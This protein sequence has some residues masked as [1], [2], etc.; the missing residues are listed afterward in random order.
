MADHTP[1]TKSSTKLYIE[2]LVESFNS[3]ECDVPEEVRRGYKI[4]L[5]ACHNAVN[6]GCGNPDSMSVALGAIVCAIAADRLNQKKQTVLLTKEVS[7]EVNDRIHKTQ[8]PVRDMPKDAQGRVVVASEN[9]TGLTFQSKLFSLSSKGAAGAIAAASIIIAAVV[10]GGNIWVNTKISEVATQ[11][12]E[13]AVNQIV[14]M[15]SDLFP[16]SK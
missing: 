4:A 1:E 12:A 10:F 14:A 16:P 7:E 6:G 13:R 2:E 8:C 9:G 5:N 11:S 3:P 15:R